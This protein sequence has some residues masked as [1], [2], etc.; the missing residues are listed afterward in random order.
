MGPAEQAGEPLTAIALEIQFDFDSATLTGGARQVLDQLGGALKSDALESF[1]F[2]VEGHTDSVG[3]EGYNLDLSE[4]R[5]RAVSTY[6]TREFGVEAA[7]LKTIG[8]GEAEP[9]DVSN[10][11]SGVNRRVQIVNLGG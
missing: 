5:A 6:L 3:S 11:A 10:P 7:R 4:R 8:R 2:L 9:F 1:A